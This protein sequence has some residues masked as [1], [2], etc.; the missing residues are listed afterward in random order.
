MGIKVSLGKKCPCDSYLTLSIR[1][2][3]LTCHH[4]FRNND[5]DLEEVWQSK[6]SILLC[7]KCRKIN[8]GK[9][10]NLSKIKMER[11]ESCQNKDAQ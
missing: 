9:Y 10:A 3:T 6:K 5:G 1:R 2:I 4:I 11:T 7:A 8:T